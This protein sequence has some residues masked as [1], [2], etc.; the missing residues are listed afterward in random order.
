ML[1]A[2]ERYTIDCLIIG[3][4]PDMII[5]GLDIFYGLCVGIWSADDMYYSNLI[6]DQ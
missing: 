4:Y 2:R 5:S 3:V 1:L 6:G